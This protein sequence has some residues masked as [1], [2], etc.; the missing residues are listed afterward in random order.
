MTNSMFESLVSIFEIFEKYLRN[1]NNLFESLVSIF[2]GYPE[3]NSV[4]TQRFRNIKT[5]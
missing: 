5:V 1:D 2:H 4:W 3:Q